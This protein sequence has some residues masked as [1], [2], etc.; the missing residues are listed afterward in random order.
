MVTTPLEMVRVT[1]EPKSTAPENSHT[2]PMASALPMDTAPV[3]TDVPSALATS[4][5]PSAA[6]S[7]KEMAS[8][9]PTMTNGVS[10]GV[11]E[12]RC[13]QAAVVSANDIRGGESRGGG[14]AVKRCGRC[15]A[16]R[17]SCGPRKRSRRCGKCG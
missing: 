9:R 12:A 8:A 7:R 5:A 17:R 2:A 3:P 6:E 14:D 11:D 1:D 4:L 15:G 16:L 13:R 10:S